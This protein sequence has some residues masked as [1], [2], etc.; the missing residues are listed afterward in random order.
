MLARARGGKHATVRAAM[1]TQGLARWLR[2]E[3]RSVW[4]EALRALLLPLALLYGLL[5]WV[6]G[7]CTRTMPLPVPVISVGNLELGGTGKSVLVRWL[8]LRLQAQ[9]LRVL[10]VARGYGAPT[11]AGLDEEGAEL[12][13]AGLRCAQGRKRHSTAMAALAQEPADVI[14]LDDG[15]QHRRVQRAVE[16]LLYDAARP[17]GAGWPLPAGSLRG[18]A[19]AAPRP[20]L[21]VLTRVDEVDAA[22]LQH[23]RE[24]LE[25]M[26]PGVPQVCMIHAPMQ[27][28]PTGAVAALAGKRVCLL[29]GMAR[30]ASLHRMATSV[31]AVVVHEYAAADHH[32]WTQHELSAV[33]A[34][35]RRAG[36]ELLL[37]S[38]KDW[39][40]LRFMA[41]ELPLRA[42]QV[43]A[44]FEP[45]EVGII[46]AILRAAL[47]PRT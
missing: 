18:F 33:D 47:P 31:G 3:K 13:A 17:L 4:G 40:K 44:Q 23:T 7:A 21:V 34:Q 43:Q 37:T 41:T 15:A 1:N 9:G 16:I 11:A 28:L 26:H 45:D 14:L 5:A 27:L 12:E 24:L 32:P 35:A 10:V 2:G 20:H 19:W 36:A 25:R 30:P 29:S 6:R 46:D 22:T 39:P 8:G 42:L 38:G